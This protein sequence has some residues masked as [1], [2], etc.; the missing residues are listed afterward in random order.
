MATQA[1]LGSLQSAVEAATRNGVPYGKILNIGEW[2]L[3]FAAP[4]NAG[5]LPSLI[6]ALMK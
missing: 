4:R 3:K 5:D 1:Q 2:E 6:H